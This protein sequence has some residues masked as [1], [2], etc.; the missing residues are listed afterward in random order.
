MLMRV[1]GNPPIA[2]VFAYMAGALIGFGLM[3]VLAQGALTREQSLDHPA[4]RVLAGAMNWF[5]AGVAVGA[6]ALIAELDSAVAWALGSFAATTIYILC[7]ST[8]LAFVSTRRRRAA[9]AAC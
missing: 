1:H 3:S 6:V 2:A 5:A 7:A 9:H 8:Q 4:D